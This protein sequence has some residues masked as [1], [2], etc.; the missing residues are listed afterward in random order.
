MTLPQQRWRN[1]SG[2]LELAE[3]IANQANISALFAQILI[4]RGIN[5]E[6]AVQEF[7]HPQPDNLPDPKQVF[8]DLIPS[9][10]CLERVK[11][12]GLEVAICGD[13]DVDGMTSTALLLRTFAALGI[14]ADYEIPSRM[15]EGYGIN[16]RMVRE[17]H[18]R[19]VALIITVDNGI[20]ALGAISLAK[21]LGMMVI[22]TDHHELPETLPPADGILNPKQ[23]SIDSPYYTIAGVG[24]AY[25]LGTELAKR[26]QTNPELEN[27]LLELFT[28]G[29]IAD[30]ASLTGINRQ[31][32][33]R[34]LKLLA[35]SQI[36]G[37]QALK[38]V[39]GI[40]DRAIKPDSIGFTLGPRINAVGRIGDPTIV[41]EL[42]TTTDSGIALERAM[43][44]EEINRERQRLCTEI[45]QEAVALV[46]EQ[47]AT[48]ELDLLRD[49]VLMLLSPKWH[50]GVIGIVA[51]RLV[52]RFGAPVFMCV[53]EPDGDVRSSARGIPEFNVFDAL[54]N[55]HDLLGKF[56]GHF[57]AGG[58][59]TTIEKVELLRER[60][61]Q[62]ARTHLTAEQICPAIAIDL[63]MPLSN[64]TASLYQELEKL[65]PCGIGNSVPIF[66][67][68]NV[69]IISQKIFGKTQEHLSFFLDRGDGR[70]LK[71]IAWRWSNYYPLP[72]YVDL[73][74]KIQQKTDREETYLELELVGVQ[75]NL[76]PEK[77]WQPTIQQK[78]APPIT[79]AIEWKEL[80]LA[81]II[82]IPNPSLIYGYNYPDRLFANADRDR[83][84]QIYEALIL[85]N[86]PP[87]IFHLQWL[88]ALGKPKQ[89]YLRSQ[90]EIDSLPPIPS[91]AQLLKSIEELDGTTN[92][93]L[94]ELAQKWWIAP[95]AIVAGLREMGCECSAYR[96][97]DS[98]EHELAA[99]LVWYKTEIDQI[100]SEFTA[101]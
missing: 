95:Q 71:A 85:W 38:Q 59:S 28:L 54:E 56:G 20:S 12:L 65:Q 53:S 66:A 100:Q 55:S 23:I 49:R 6:A 74:Y 83:P 84:T 75:A 68:R 40:S 15:T 29:T 82:Q 97:T 41:I 10:D 22:I 26:F 94:M 52:E 5:T 90:L 43:Q 46:H 16:E 1:F 48:T 62:F 69:R 92:L 9:L 57:A 86:L 35:D 13:Y 47:I 99:Q 21:E 30:L 27:I 34:G 33:Q 36:L 31:L 78:N 17:L 64:V 76:N 67:S 32:V 44:C 96:S 80:D 45:E 101:T 88:I 70:R 37:L 63:E 19:G 81:Q 61:R 2:N 42:L 14:K 7:L 18:E 91:A 8:T 24:V 79:T 73:A 39:S 4:N 50:H 58:F 60:L 72:E 25:L 93:N 89:I 87:S 11:R 77:S 98:L 3:A 51:S